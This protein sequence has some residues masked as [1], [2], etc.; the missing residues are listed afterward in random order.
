MAELRITMRHAQA[1]GMCS[2]GAVKKMRALGFSQ[3]KIHDVLKNGLPLSEARLLGD[4]QMDKII[5]KALEQEA[6]NG[7]G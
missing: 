6:Q 5:A 4:A 7:E 3:E 1:A 2:R